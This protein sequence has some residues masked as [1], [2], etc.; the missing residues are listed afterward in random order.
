VS[1]HDAGIR[2]R[3]LGFGRLPHDVRGDVERDGGVHVGV[4]GECRVPAGLVFDRG[5]QADE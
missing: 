1:D 3:V 5:V 4:H 2:A